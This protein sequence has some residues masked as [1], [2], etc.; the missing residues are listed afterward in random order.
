MTI[1]L[2]HRIEPSEYR[3]N[4]IIIEQ[5]VETIDL[6][7]CYELCLFDGNNFDDFHRDIQILSKQYHCCNAKGK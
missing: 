1:T 4:K 5:H 2:S 6:S 7:K 3:F